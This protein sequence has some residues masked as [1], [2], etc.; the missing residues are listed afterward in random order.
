MFAV[1]NASYLIVEELEV[2]PPINQSSSSLKHLRN[3]NLHYKSTMGNLSSAL[4]WS[5]TTAEGKERS[6][7]AMLIDPIGACIQRADLTP[8]NPDA[9]EVPA[10][11]ADANLAEPVKA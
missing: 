11:P 8:W 7:G 3:L 9:V 10:E 2:I 1:H 4:Y 6:I 5:T